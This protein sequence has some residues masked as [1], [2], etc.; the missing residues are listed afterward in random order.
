[1]QWLDVFALTFLFEITY[2][3]WN[4][5]ANFCY[6]N[7]P[8]SESLSHPSVLYWNDATFILL[9]L[10]AIVRLWY[11]IYLVRRDGQYRD[12]KDLLSAFF[13]RHLKKSLVLLASVV[14]TA[15]FLII[16]R[17]NTC[18][19][20]VNS[21]SPCDDLYRELSSFLAYC[22][23][24]VIIGLLVALSLIAESIILIHYA[25]RPSK[26]WICPVF[27]AYKFGAWI[28]WEV[29]ECLQAQKIV[30]GTDSDNNI[31]IVAYLY[32][33][34][35]T[36]LLILYIQERL[37]PGELRDHTDHL[38]ADENFTG[39]NDKEMNIISKTSHQEPLETEEQEHDSHN[40]N[41]DSKSS[42]AESIEEVQ[43]DESYHRTSQIIDDGDIDEE[44]H[45]VPVRD[46]N[47]WKSKKPVVILS[48]IQPEDQ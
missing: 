13:S 44:L 7:L 46:K 23:L 30:I 10:V 20:T 33:I 28:G 43:E 9:F 17:F 18:D 2:F 6:S 26:W 4:L 3:T 8:S 40:V 45:R 21:S 34:S 36:N 42:T 31:A 22:P 1:M 29:E 38:L 39:P 48:P 12:A 19:C 32:L 24:V 5:Y 16:Q 25:R 47:Y 41:E 11:A 14:G 15:L 35:L 37:R 27:F